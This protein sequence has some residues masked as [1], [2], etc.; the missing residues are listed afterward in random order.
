M[1]DELGSIYTD[2]DVAAL[3]PSRGQ[4]AAV[5]W[6]LALILVF[7]FVESLSDE[8]AMETVRG[9]IDW[10]DALSLALDDSGFDSSILSEFRDRLIAGS[11]EHHL[12][13][14]MLTHFKATG[15]LKARGRQRT[16][17]TH[18]LAAVRA[19]NRL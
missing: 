3:F 1:R 5:P 14:A 11:L 17:S 2:Q 7:P 12:L 9:R 19:L 8:Q 6:R 15:L 16:D 18:V 4:P 13:N 10:K